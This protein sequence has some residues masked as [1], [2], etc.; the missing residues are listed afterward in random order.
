[1]PKW[2]QSGGSAT[3]AGIRAV[4]HNQSYNRTPTQILQV[5]FDQ[6]RLICE[7]ATS[8]AKDPYIYGAKALRE[9]KGLTQVAI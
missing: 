4:S 9:V 5:K 7:N 1:M 3:R 2:D 8:F 6:Q